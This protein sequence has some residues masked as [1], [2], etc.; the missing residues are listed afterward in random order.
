MHVKQ[1]TCSNSES[2]IVCQELSFASRWTSLLIISSSRDSDHR[3]IHEP[4]LTWFII[5]NLIKKKI[6]KMF[7]L[8]LNVSRVIAFSHLVWSNL[9][10]ALQLKY[11]LLKAD[12]LFT[13]FHWQ[14]DEIVY[15]NPSWDHTEFALPELVSLFW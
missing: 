15:V 14:Y 4:L 7:F 3:S 12:I 5:C 11:S 8:V 10:T 6:Y 2:A 13:V 1:T 9:N